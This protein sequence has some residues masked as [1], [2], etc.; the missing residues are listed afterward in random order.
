MDTFVFIAPPCSPPPL[1]TN[2]CE[3]M[4]S[5]QKWLDMSSQCP[6][7]C[8]A[9]KLHSEKNNPFWKGKQSGSADVGEPQD[10]HENN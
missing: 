2:G 5:Y 3:L 6:P 8:S 7:D 1:L 9:K 10:M 4:A